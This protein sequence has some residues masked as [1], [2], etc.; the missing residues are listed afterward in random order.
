MGI[1]ID[2]LKAYDT[3]NKKFVGYKLCRM[4]FPKSLVD[5]IYECISTPTFSIHVGGISHGFITSNKG[6]RQ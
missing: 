3:V 2:L 6:L 1:K 4:S 5:L